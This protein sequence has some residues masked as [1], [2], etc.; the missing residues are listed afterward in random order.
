MWTQNENR[1]GFTW[2]YIGTYWFDAGANASTGSVVASN[3]SSVAGQQVVVDAVRFGGGVGDYNDGGGVSGKP[4]WEESGKYYAGFMG[5]TYANGTVNAMPA[6]AAWECEDSWEG[7]TNNNAM[8]LAWHSN[9]NTG[10]DRGTIS[11]AYGSGGWG[12]AFD[13]IAGGDVLRNSIHDEMINDIRAGWDASWANLGKT[14]NWYGEINPG[15]NGKMPAALIE[16]AFHD[17]AADTQALLDPRFR[18]LVARSVYQ[19]IVKFYYNYFNL[20]KGNTEFNDATLLPE[21]PIRPRVTSNADGTVTVAWNA[22][23]FNSGNNL[24]GNAAT[25]YK[26]YRSPNGKGFDNGTATAATSLVV[27]G[28]TAGEPVYFRITATNSGGES[29]PSE[30]LAVSPRVGSSVPVLIVN[31][32]DRIDGAANIREQN[33]FGS[34]GDTIQ[35]G[36]LNRMNTYDYAIAHAKA[37]HAFGRDFDCASNEAVEAGSVNLGSYDTV[38]WIL[39]EES[40]TDDTFSATEQT[41]VSAY[42]SA[43]GSLLVTGSDVGYEL[44]GLGR[45]TSFFNGTLRASYVADSAGVY[46]ASGA[47]GGAFNGLALAFDN[48]AAIYNVDSADV[49][50]PFSGSTAA[51]YY[52]GGTTTVDSFD[53]IAGWQDPNWS[54]STTAAA[55]STFAIVTTP[56]RE[57]TGSG[58]IYYDFSTG[59]FLREVTTTRPSFPISAPLSVWV[60]GDNSGHQVRLCVRDSETNYDL[61]VNPYTTIDFTGWRQITWNIAANPGTKY[62][63][64]AGSDGVFTGPNALLDSIQV[65][66][67]GTATTG[68]LYVDE[69]TAA[70]GAGTQVAGIQWQGT[71]GNGRLIYLAFPFEAVT[72]D[73]NRNAL[74]SAA[75]TYFDTPVPARVT[76]F[77]LY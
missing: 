57:G 59:T 17:N 55:A 14:T 73:A 69:M 25:G 15:N 50:A 30:V 49:I 48:G 35:R 4:R 60:Y 10:S 28:L 24:L 20:T 74:M 51:M 45:A 67:T 56:K 64:V 63:S 75:L 44:Q 9:A 66:K 37:I 2:K 16:V 70:T 36:Y 31:G 3:L 22:P 13:G 1:D 12:T 21:P 32:F 58:D 76:E 43:G 47:A 39:G 18:Q 19:G 6:Y 62:A 52:G 53:A 38:V 23:P 46:T 33:P 68:H 71:G 34:A 40:D 65:N 11:F 27:S 7:G 41:K 61:F 42:L 29:F 77:N 8:Y 5:Q 26:V 54:G 72:T